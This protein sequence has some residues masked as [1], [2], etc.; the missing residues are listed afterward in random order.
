MNN[1]EH[2]YSKE[3]IKVSKHRVVIK[4]LKNHYNNQLMIHYYLLD[5]NPLSPLNQLKIKILVS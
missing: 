3:V 2:L 4:H 5:K 1:N